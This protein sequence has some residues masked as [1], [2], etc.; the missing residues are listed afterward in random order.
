LTKKSPARQRKE[1]VREP[2]A[3]YGGPG[4]EVAL[5]QAADGKISLEVRLEKETLW[6]TQK[7]MAML[8]DTERSVITKHLRNIFN[9][10]ELKEKSNVQKMHIPGSDKLVAFYNL[11]VIISVGYRVNSKRG[12]QFRIWATQVLKDHLLKGYTVNAKR[13]EELKQAIH[14][15]A[16]VADR[17]RLSGDEA[18]ALLKV[19][20]E[21]SFALNLLDDYDHGRPPEVT[22]KPQP[23][24]PVGL[25][26][27]RRIVTVLRDRFGGSPLFGREKD[28]G[29]E[30]SLNAVFQTAGGQELYPSREEKAAN[31]LY[32]LVKNH[33]FVDGNKRI[34]AA[35]FLWFL[36]KNGILTDAV[37]QARISQEALVALTLMIAES[38]P[39]ERKM[40][41]HLTVA[42]LE[43]KTKSM[44]GYDER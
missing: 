4:G 29:L 40:M 12:T 30:G 43:E 15:V 27:A 8:F 6:L 37:G 19:V 41:T 22:A 26:E 35:I 7:Q 24:V 13:L 14:V 39:K 33:H 34:G 5:Y 18:T 3:A 44:G 17:R 9:S 20:S 28:E 21:Y 1:A 25:E 31:L 38:D 42:L 2:S 11:D 36:E 16:R 23:T 32:F 10:G